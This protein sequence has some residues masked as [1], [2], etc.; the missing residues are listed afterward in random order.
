M[1]LTIILP[2]DAYESITSKR[3]AE[4]NYLS[5]ES[6]HVGRFQTLK[7]VIN[8]TEVEDSEVVIQVTIDKVYQS[9]T[10]TKLEEIKV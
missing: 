3:S 2:E 10:S 9:V 5:G 4:S 1:K 7:Q 8:E 6:V